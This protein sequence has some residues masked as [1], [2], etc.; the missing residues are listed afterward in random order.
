LSDL[1]CRRGSLGEAVVDLRDLPGPLLVESSEL[2]G[3]CADGRTVGRIVVGVDG[4]APADAVL[5]L[6]LA[7]SRFRGA[8]L[9]VVCAWEMPATVWSGSYVTPDFTT[10][11]EQEASQIIDESLT[12]VGSDTADVFIER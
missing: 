11:L 3:E 5:R 7:E 12:R 8:G 1:A 6:A 4:S 10:A 2:L 9:R